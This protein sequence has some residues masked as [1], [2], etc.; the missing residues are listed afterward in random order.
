VTGIA[1]RPGA[2]ASGCSDRTPPVSTF[3]R[4]RGVQATRKRKR[5]SLM[6][7]SSDRGGRAHGAGRVKNVR[8]AVARRAGKRCRFL[9]GRKGFTKARSC[10]KPIF[11]TAKGTTH[12]RF[13]FRGH[14]AKGR[15]I[16]YVR[17][18]D[19]AGN[20]PRKLPKP[21]IRAFRVR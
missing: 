11:M 15:Y 18:T 10:S 6:G 16:A 4:K 14:L 1:G 5:L 20:V 8:V 3:A 2:A 19:S 9:K 21:A 7:T 13:A 17:G 12:W